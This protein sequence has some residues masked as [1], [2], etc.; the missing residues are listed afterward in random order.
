[1][2]VLI[3]QETGWASEQS[4]HGDEVDFF[5]RTAFPILFIYGWFNCTVSSSD[6]MVSND[7]LISE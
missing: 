1:M 6:N 5:I 4:G 2:E 7:K 3:G